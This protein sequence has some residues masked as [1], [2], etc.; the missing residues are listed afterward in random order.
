MVDDRNQNIN[1]NVPSLK[2]IR[3]RLDLTQEEFG[4][5]LGMAANTISRHERGQHKIRFSVSQV[6][7]LKELLEQAGMSI[8]DLP[9]DID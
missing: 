1:P 7:R 5:A 4:K 8:D 3:L 6:K 2:E 9:D